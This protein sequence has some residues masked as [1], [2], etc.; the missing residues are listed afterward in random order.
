M[1]RRNGRVHFDDR[2]GWNAT[3]AQKG[4][5]GKRRRDWHHGKGSEAHRH[6]PIMW[7]DLGTGADPTSG[8]PQPIRRKKQRKGSAA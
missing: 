1:G 2:G 6:D 4:K 7:P 5:G 8:A 3:R